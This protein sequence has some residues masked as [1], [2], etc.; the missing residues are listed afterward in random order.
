[1]S[2]AINGQAEEVPG[3]D[4]RSFLDPDGPPHTVRVYKRSTAPS[5]IVLHT[6]IGD[7]DCHVIL[8]PDG[9]PATTTSDVSATSLARRQAKMP[10]KP[11]PG[12]K[13]RGAASEHLIVSGTGRAFQIADLATEA[14]WHATGCNPHTIGIEICQSEDGPPVWSARK[15]MNV[16][17][18]GV[19]L[20][21]Y[22]AT[23]KLVHWIC[24]RFD[25]PKRLPVR[26]GQLIK[27]TVRA[28]NQ[29]NHGPAGKGWPGVF[30][31]YHSTR[32]KGL[33]DPGTIIQQMLLD[34]GF[35]GVDPDA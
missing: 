17:R 19:Y 20:A 13:A 28:L 30:C 24:Q 10:P 11:P 3:L 31:H 25:I 16:P 18:W 5:G 8:G 9:Q 2:L 22:V 21:A 27:R 1:M 15:G 33:Y 34:S 35:E 14:A 6:I 26:G 12:K 23:V 32:N 29:D 7:A 4:T